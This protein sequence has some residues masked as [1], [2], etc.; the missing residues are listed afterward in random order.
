MKQSMR[1]N[2]RQILR[3]A[4]NNLGSGSVLP[5]LLLLIPE[6]PRTLKQE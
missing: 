2:D 5:L 3:R 1:L 6:I 4:L